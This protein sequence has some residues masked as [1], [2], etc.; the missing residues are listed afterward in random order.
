[1]KKAMAAIVFVGLA[2]SASIFAAPAA[3]AARAA[4]APAYSLLEKAYV[5]AAREYAPVWKKVPARSLVPA[6]WI[7]CGQLTGG[8]TVSQVV[9]PVG[10]APAW[11]T[12]LARF[13]L[14]ASAVSYLC[15]EHDSKV[16]RYS[17]TQQL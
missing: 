17:R 12:K 7:I 1:M 15:P 8:L 10:G 4:S 6:G 5:A 9:E 16:A 3:S 2:A 14:V 11:A 13:V